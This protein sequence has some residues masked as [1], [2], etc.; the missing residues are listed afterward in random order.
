MMGAVTVLEGLLPS[1]P[2]SVILH[3]L[4]C[5]QSCLGVIMALHT[6]LSCASA[7]RCCT[8]SPAQAPGGILQVGPATA[9]DGS[10][11]RP[12]ELLQLLLAP[13]VH[14]HA[15]P[16]L[17]NRVAGLLLQVAPACYMRP[18][19]PDLDQGQQHQ[20]CHRCAAA[21]E[22]LCGLMWTRRRMLVPSDCT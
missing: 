8:V 16:Q 4:V 15:S 18:S 10:G 17:R 14:R 11:T 3:Q 13:E 22:C 6:V 19:I 20:T 12:T 21:S 9:A 7:M 1:L 5:L 2:E